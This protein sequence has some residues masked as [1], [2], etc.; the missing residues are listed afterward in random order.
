MVT[1]YNR[2]IYIYVETPT[3][4]GFATR[5][6]IRCAFIGAEPWYHGGRNFRYRPACSRSRVH[7]ERRTGGG[8]GPM[9][10]WSLLR[11]L[12]AALTLTGSLHSGHPCTGHRLPQQMWVVQAMARGCAGSCRGCS[13]SG[14]RRAGPPRRSPVSRRLSGDGPTGARFSAHPPSSSLSDFPLN[15]P[16]T[17]TCR[18]DLIV[19]S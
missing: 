19:I 7:R 1:I 8:V 12:G 3:V 13:R 2:A 5:M 14:Y 9:G 15:P 6:T 11:S 4:R 17:R 10:C 16:I 18:G